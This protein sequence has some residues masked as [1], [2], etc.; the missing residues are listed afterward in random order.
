MAL[1]RTA[2]DSDKFMRTAAIDKLFREYGVKLGPQ[3]RNAISVASEIKKHR[4]D[5]TSKDPHV[6]IRAWVHEGNP[7]AV[8]PTLIADTGR[9]LRLDPRLVAI[10]DRINQQPAMKALV[11]NVPYLAHGVE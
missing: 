7:E 6:V 10:R 5:F 8:K 9:P 11:S 3:Q 2:S 4:P 1:P